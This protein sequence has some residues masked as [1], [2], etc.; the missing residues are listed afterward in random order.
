M[1]FIVKFENGDQPFWL[2]DWT[3]DP[4]RTLVEKNA[5]DFDKYSQAERAMNKAIKNYPERKLKGR[6]SIEAKI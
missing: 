5:R 3:G 4:G 2:A 6:S 1:G